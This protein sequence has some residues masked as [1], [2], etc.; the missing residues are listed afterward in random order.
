M[1][2]QLLGTGAADGVPNPFCRCHTCSAALAA[3]EVRGQTAAL[4]DDVLLVDC[5]PEVPRSATR[6]GVSLAAVQ[7]LLLTHSHPDHAGPT[8]ALFRSWA[9]CD[10]TLDLV[11][12][13]QALDVFRDWVGPSDPVRFVVVEPG[14]T[15]E[16]GQHTVRVLAA[17]H[18]DPM[19]GPGL[20]YDITG[21]DGG[22][23]LY[24]TDTGPLPPQTVEAVAGR[25]FDVVL[26]EETFGDVAHETD[27]LDL[28]SFPLALTGL[29][30]VGAITDQTDVVAVHLGH[31]NPPTAELDAR[32]RPWGARVVPDGSV[33]DTRAATRTDGPVPIA[34][35]RRGRCTFVVGGARSGKSVR[36]EALTAELATP[37]RRVTY[38]ATGGQRAGD[39]EWVER[40]RL[41]RARRPATWVTVETTDLVAALDEATTDDVLL[42]DC[43][44]LWLATQLD[45]AGTW[46]ASDD[47][48]HT[49]AAA[50][51]DQSISDV[52]LALGHTAGQVVVV[53][54]E[55]G[56]GVV[57]ATV[58]GRIY[59]DTLGRLNV[60][61]AEVST[62][63]VL[64]VAGQ[65]LVLKSERTEPTR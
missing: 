28:V 65:P 12:P 5:G 47:E 39:L 36:A 24:A 27:H 49:R 32:L 16:L 22:R 8:A 52:L 58:S 63:V 13:A 41:H 31:H 64:V 46:S 43:L 25:A 48:A 23:L 44:S 29:R 45:D 9:G 21:A 50:V 40:I 38:V 61:V 56:S 35:E 55:V 15:L 18:G 34:G 59:R 10:L 51:V 6:H 62:H 37:D 2:V 26:L 11:G 19:T 20:L 7:H 53:S 3:G 42:I 4:V 1:R 57:P 33:L 54:N 30:E 17:S 14:Q 60:A